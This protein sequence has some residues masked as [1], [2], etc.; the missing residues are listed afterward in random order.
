MAIALLTV[1][2][3][4]VIPT[5]Q[6]TMP[7]MSILPEAVSWPEDTNSQEVPSVDIDNLMNAFVENRGQYPSDV[8]FFSGSTST[9]AAFSPGSVT[10]YPS[11]D[12]DGSDDNSI[13]IRFNGSNSVTP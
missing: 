2:I 9:K 7:D 13:T 10:Y 5:V 1:V 3:S 11:V 8:L 4:P 6:G 12:G